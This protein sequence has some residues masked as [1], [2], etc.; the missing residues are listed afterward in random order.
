MTTSSDRSGIFS[1]AKS[2]SSEFSGTAKAMAGAAS[3]QAA[4]V[5]AQAQQLAKEQFDNLAEAIRR[6]PIQ[7]TGI[8]AGIGFVLAMIARR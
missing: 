6:K 2:E 7:A 1:A 3:D 8:A 5:A 4:E